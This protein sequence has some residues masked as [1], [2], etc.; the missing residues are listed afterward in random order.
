[1]RIKSI[2]IDNESWEIGALSLAQVEEVVAPLEEITGKT[3]MART[4]DIVV[5]GLNNPI[6]YAAKKAGTDV[7]VTKL[8]DHERVRTELD[9]ISLPFVK[10][11][12]LDFSSLKQ[13]AEVKADATGEEQ[14]P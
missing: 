11:Q 13:Q 5:M 14:I 8:W 9:L 7:D 4:N 2:S 3:A 6:R 12:I 1:M 10:D